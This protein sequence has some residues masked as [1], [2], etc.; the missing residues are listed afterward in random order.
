MYYCLRNLCSWKSCNPNLKVTVTNHDF[1][2]L[3]LRYE[4][5]YRNPKFN[6]A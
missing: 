2:S 3:V 1:N 4:F 5:D 6:L